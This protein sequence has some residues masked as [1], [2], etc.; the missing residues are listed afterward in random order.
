[1]LEEEINKVL[2]KK[3]LKPLSA[4][5]KTIY[6]ERVLNYQSQLKRLQSELMHPGLVDP[7]NV[8]LYK[9]VAEFMRPSIPGAEAVH[10]RFSMFD[11]NKPCGLK[12]LVF[13]ANKGQADW[14][15]CL[16]CETTVTPDND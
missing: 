8:E 11:P 14:Y 10:K 2:A 3:N 7:V 1:M 13:I 6:A 5:E 12:S 9:Q 16:Q 15:Y 4:E